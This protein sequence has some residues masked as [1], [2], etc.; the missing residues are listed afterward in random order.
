MS[1]IRAMEEVKILFNRFTSFVDRDI[2]GVHI[3]CYSIALFGLTVALR[4]VRPF[5]KFKRPEDIPNHFITEK[6]ELA[7]LVKR[8]DPNGALLMVEHK[9]LV[10]IPIISSG[11]LPVKISG[12]NVTGLGLNWLQAIVAG[13]EIKFVPVVK[14]EDFVHCEVLLIQDTKQNKPELLNVGESLVKIGF[15]QTVSI[16]SPLLEDTQLLSYYKKLQAA[17]NYALRKQLGLKY[18]IKPTK[19]SLQRLLKN[20]TNLS[21]VLTKSTKKQIKRLSQ[22]SSA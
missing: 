5:S 22:L 21:S 4:K 7:G 19:K 3:G 14:H 2:K 16:Q 1:E 11:Q 17:E 10:N 20:L 8:I 15:A 18:Y 6:R 9:P 13:R 12:V